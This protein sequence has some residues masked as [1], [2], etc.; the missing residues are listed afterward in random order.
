VKKTG[1]RFREIIPMFVCVAGSALFNIGMYSFM[2]IG[3]STLAILPI[4]FV[5]SEGQSK[6]E[7]GDSP[8]A[9]PYYMGKLL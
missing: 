7:T 5:I 3:I 2:I 1:V 4:A 6:E 9:V 8:V